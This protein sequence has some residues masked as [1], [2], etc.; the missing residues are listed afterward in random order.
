MYTRYVLQE[1]SFL[2]Q[3]CESFFTEWPARDC[4]KS[5]LAENQSSQNSWQDI[6]LMYLLLHSEGQFLK[7]EW[8]HWIICFIWF[9]IKFFYNYNLISVNDDNIPVEAS[10]SVD[11]V[12]P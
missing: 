12:L 6:Y 4:R 5:V 9:S 3:K 2:A 1:G 8:L 10:V 7:C 11:S